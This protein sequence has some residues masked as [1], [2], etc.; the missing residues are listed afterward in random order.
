MWVSYTRHWLQEECVAPSVEVIFGE[1][2]VY[3]CTAQW[4]VKNTIT[5]Q[6]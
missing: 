5:D 1:Y 4:K 6:Y 3:L 2:S